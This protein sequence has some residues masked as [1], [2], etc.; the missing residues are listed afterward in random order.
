[1]TKM[2]HLV[3]EQ[4]LAVLPK[5]LAGSQDNR[6]SARERRYVSSHVE[7]LPLMGVPLAKRRMND[8]D[9]TATG[10]ARHDPILVLV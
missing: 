9:A 6:W 8:D 1:M 7:G 2:H 5:F 4:V 3:A 10:S